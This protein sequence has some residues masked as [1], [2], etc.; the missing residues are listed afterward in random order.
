MKKK[1]L[2]RSLI[3]VGQ[4]FNPGKIKFSQPPF[5][6]SGTM[7]STTEIRKATEMSSGGI[8]E[9]QPRATSPEKQKIKTRSR[10]TI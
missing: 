7:F 3:S 6:R 1:K 8:T 10:G 2:R 4:G 9:S 5:Q